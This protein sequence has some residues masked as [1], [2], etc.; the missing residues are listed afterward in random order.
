MLRR[1]GALDRPGAGPPLDHPDRGPGRRRWSRATS[2]CGRSPSTAR[3]CGS[4][5][6]GLTRVALEEGSMIVNSS[7]GGG[8]KDTWVLCGP[9]PGRSRDDADA[10][11]APEL[12]VMPA[13]PHASLDRPAAAA[14]AARGRRRR[15]MLARIAHE[16]YWI[17]RYVARADDTARML[18]GLFQASLQAPG[19]ADAPACPLGGGDGGAGRGGGAHRPRSRSEPTRGAGAD[20]R[21]REPRLGDGV[22]RPGARGREDGSATSS[23]ARCGRR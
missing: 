3:S 11:R 21:P 12:P 20:P 23:R 6:G 17:G 7:R 15:L 22:R 9:S 19:G 14:A 1:P 5:P 4:I 16:L 8:S 10:A 2:T 18:D 13:I